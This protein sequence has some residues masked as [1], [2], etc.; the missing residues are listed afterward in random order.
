M[1]PNGP[2]GNSFPYTD[3]H[4]MNTDWL[5]KIAK[6]FLDQYSHIEQT[7]SDGED[8]LTAKAEELEGLLQEWYNTHSEDIAGELADA[9]EDIGDALTDALADFQ[10]GAEARAAAV[11]A[12]IPE[13]YTT[14]SNNVTRLLSDAVRSGRQVLDNSTLTNVIASGDFNDLTSSPYVYY[15]NGLTAGTHQAVT[16]MTGMLLIFKYSTTAIGVCQVYVGNNGQLAYRNSHGSSDN[17]TWDDWTLID[18]PYYMKSG[19]TQIN[20]STYDDI[21]DS[22]DFNNLYADNA[23][24]YCHNLE[25]A[26]HQP[27]GLMSGM[28]MVFKYRPASSVGLMQIYFGND[29]QVYYRTSH[30]STLYWDRWR[31]I[32]ANTSDYTV[33]IFRKVVCCGDSYT[34]GYIVDTQDNINRY[35][36]AYAWPSAMARIT[37][38]DYINCGVSGANCA[39]WLDNQRGLAAAQLSGKAQAYIL[40]LG[41]NDASEDV[42]RHLDLG[43][44]ED[45]GQDV[46]TYY[47]RYS[48]IIRELALISPD[49]HIF[50]TTIPGPTSGQEDYNTAVSDIVTAYAE[51]YNVYLV[52]LDEYRDMFRIPSIT[53]DKRSGHYT[54]IGYEQFGE[55]LT[56]VISRVINSN[57][58]KFI[59]VN[60]IPF[61]SS[62]TQSSIEVILNN[63][64][65]TAVTFSNTYVSATGRYYTMADGNVVFSVFIR[66]KANVNSGVNNIL[67][68]L[69][70]PA[71]TDVMFYE[72]DIGNKIRPDRYLT[73]TTGW[74]LNNKHKSGDYC[75]FYGMYTPS[76]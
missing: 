21:M 9:L 49:A 40:A 1:F 74:R 26:L 70:T 22:G 5:I 71:N 60:L 25:S 43:T 37:G 66:M 7:I 11:I 8:S 32:G 17:P 10:T 63:N 13:D 56:K 59:D 46:D 50:C 2:F 42:G 12:T 44:S 64:T 75:F 6:D 23:I 29:G 20:E 18:V 15:C 69:P 36:E 73:Y 51:T 28:F 68:G 76:T 31:Q 52:D 4:A 24:Y 34:A 3:F 53:G 45:I 62:P 27:V 14:L 38:N 67:T 58:S 41:L 65:A 61:D 47:G 55:I 48:Q 57:L 39:Q 16:T 33:R 35:N 54:S 72:Y 30:G 19:Y